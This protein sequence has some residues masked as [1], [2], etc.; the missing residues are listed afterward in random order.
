MKL[1]LRVFWMSFFA[2]LIATLR[3]VIEQLVSTVWTAPG[4]QLR[5]RARA[6]ERG[7]W[8]S[9]FHAISAFFFF[10]C[11]AERKRFLPSSGLQHFPTQAV[12][13]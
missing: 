4:T 1:L 6:Q 11:F 3:F 10:F 9:R 5:M 7:P 13:F 12:A 2:S 8:N